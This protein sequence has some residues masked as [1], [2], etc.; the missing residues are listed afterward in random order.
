[1]VQKLCR[2]TITGR[3]VGDLILEAFS[4]SY[5][6][7]SIF[8]VILR[9]RLEGKS[10]E[11][12]KPLVTM[13]TVITVTQGEVFH[14]FLHSCH[15]F[16]VIVFVCFISDSINIF[17]LFSNPSQ[18]Y[19]S[20]SILPFNTRKIFLVS[21]QQT[22]AFIERAQLDLVGALSLTA[23]EQVPIQYPSEFISG[24]SSYCRVECYSC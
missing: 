12:I 14:S 24:T 9:V 13:A 11:S 17:R 3:K 18:C 2:R 16:V 10:S 22:P 21:V 23:H 20:G 8:V 5:T 7:H 4:M 1:M 15:R 19:A 6:L